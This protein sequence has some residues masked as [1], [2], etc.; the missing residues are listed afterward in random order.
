MRAS[1]G[2]TSTNSSGCSSDRYGSC[3][4]IPPAVWCSVSRAVVSTNGNTSVRPGS[5]GFGFD[6]LSARP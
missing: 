2:D 3:R 4:L 5:R 1:S 6:G